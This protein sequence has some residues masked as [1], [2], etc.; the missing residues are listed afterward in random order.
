MIGQLYGTIA[1]KNKDSVILVCQG[2]GF[3]VSVS[4]LTMRE[5]KIEGQAKLYTKMIVR[6]DH[7]S[8][9]GFASKEEKELFELLTSVSKVGPKVGL[10]ILSS[11]EISAIRSAIVNSNVSMLSKVPGIGKKT[12]E[13]LILELKDKIRVSETVDMR[14][15]ADI[16]DSSEVL[17]V[18]LSLGFG[19]SEAIK[20]IKKISDAHPELRG[21]EMIPKVLSLLSRV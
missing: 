6:E 5:L 18:L 21:E 14:E 10:S 4:D 9:V 16:S 19:R 12:A 3:E 17:E 7:I 2:V 1:E 13:R 15:Q 11:Y 20:A 8:M